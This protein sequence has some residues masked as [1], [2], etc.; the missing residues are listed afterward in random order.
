MRPRWRYFRLA[1]RRDRY[2][3]CSTKALYFTL[4]K[5]KKGSKDY[6]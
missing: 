3:D 2:I 4:L 5:K 1:A 6:L